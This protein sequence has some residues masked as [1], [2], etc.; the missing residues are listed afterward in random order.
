MPYYRFITEEELDLIRRHRALSPQGHYPPYK[1]NEIICVFESGDLA[2]L[3]K[4]Y[5]TALTEQR[6]MG[7]GKKL[8]AIE[9]VGFSGR[10]ELDKSQNGGWPESRA[11]FDPIPLEQLRIVAQAV[12]EQMRG[13]QVSLSPLQI[14]PQNLPH[15]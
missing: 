10:M 11:I 3:F 15:L 2:A 8:I 12:V 1:P 14:E 4:R 7:T 9:V 5:G 6:E 13:G